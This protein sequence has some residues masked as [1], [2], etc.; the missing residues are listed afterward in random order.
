MDRPTRPP[1][2]NI[3]ANTKRIAAILSINDTLNLC[4][5]ALELEKRAAGAVKR[6]TRLHPL[7]EFANPDEWVCIPRGDFEE[8]RALLPSREDSAGQE[9]GRND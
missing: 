4:D 1:I 3:I 9:D 8:L 6:N 2:E 7:D 5:Y